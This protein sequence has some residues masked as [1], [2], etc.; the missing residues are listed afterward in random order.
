MKRETTVIL[1]VIVVLTFVVGRQSARHS[2][3]APSVNFPTTET[4]PV[5]AAE[6]TETA[7]ATLTAIDRAR[8]AIAAANADLQPAAVQPIATPQPSPQPPLAPQPPPKIHQDIEHDTTRIHFA[9]LL[10][11]KGDSLATDVSF[12]R[13]SGRLVIFQ[14]E[15]GPA[16]SFA[17][18]QLH[19]Q[20]LDFIGVDLY[21]ATLAEKIRQTGKERRALAAQRARAARD[22]SSR[23]R[24][25]AA[26]KESAQ[27]MQSEIAAKQDNVTDLR[28][29]AQA[30]EREAIEHSHATIDERNRAKREGISRWL[31]VSVAEV[32]VKQ[33]TPT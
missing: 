2:K 20:A 17:A 9:E 32:S 27:R 6:S 24:V 29:R 18:D 5:Q 26:S 8:A 19:P 33:A 30:R 15:S 1:S 22:A 7:Q 4:S 16:V 25:E 23:Q 12:V 11:N 10:S 3:A 28:M 13:G 14:P 21:A 31:T